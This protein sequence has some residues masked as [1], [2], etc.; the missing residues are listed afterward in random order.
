MSSD[1]QLVF[2]V[3][4][5]QATTLRYD[6]RLEI[7]GVMPSWSIP[8][9]CNFVGACGSLPICAGLTFVVVRCESEIMRLS[10]VG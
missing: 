2:V 1:Q 9:R 3:Q 10:G 7:G 6:F 4:K 5:H 8:N